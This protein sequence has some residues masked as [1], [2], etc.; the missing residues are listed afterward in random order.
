[1]G[2]VWE[3]LCDPMQAPEWAEDVVEV[4]GEPVKIEK[5][6]GVRFSDMFHGHNERVPVAGLAWG[7]EVLDAVVREIC[8][9]LATALGLKGTTPH[10]EL[11][12]AGGGE[13]S[14]QPPGRL[15]G[16]PRRPALV[17]SSRER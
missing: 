13:R 9:E 1:M 8:G 12:E 11:P 6:S 2:E 14:R 16:V 10:Q 4:T 3:T 15:Q 17:E 5:G 7:V